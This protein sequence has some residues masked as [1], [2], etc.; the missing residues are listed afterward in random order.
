L[1]FDLT[2]IYSRRREDWN[3]VGRM[4]SFIRCAALAATLALAGC[5][6]GYEEFYQPITAA[7]GQT[8]LSP[9]TGPPQLIASSGDPNRDINEM[10]ARGFWPIGYASFNGPAEGPAR[11]LEAAQKVGAQYVVAAAR[12]TNTMTG[13]IPITTP[14]TATAV[15]QGTVNAFDAGGSA[16]AQYQGTTTVYGSQTS[17]IPYSVAHYD[18][19]AVFFAPMTRHG[20][21]ALLADVSPELAQQIGTEKG[22]LIRA[23][24]RDSPAFAADILPGDVVVAIDGQPVTGMMSML[25]GLRVTKGRP[26][27]VSI[28]RGAQTLT[29]TLNVPAGDW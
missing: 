1:K 23:V 10:Y 26:V 28:Q 21:G 13:A 27:S 6:N 25:G 24:R 11:A 16:F 18:Q 17:Y 3:G 22:A 19:M 12:Y 14:T 7:G 2:G 15:S 20:A 4:K 29:K 9:L 5:A 8:P